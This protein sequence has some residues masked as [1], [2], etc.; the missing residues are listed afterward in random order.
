MSDV[1]FENASGVPAEGVVATQAVT[2]AKKIYRVK[3]CA[4]SGCN[5]EFTPVI[6]AQKF[7]E[8][9]KIRPRTDEDREYD[10]AAQQRHRDK[11]AAKQEKKDRRFDSKT[12][13]TKKEAIEIL[14]KERLIRNPHVVDK[15]VELAES[16]ARHFKI[17]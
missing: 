13:I 5:A 8:L 9:H 10:A 16:A 15:C 4:E 2:P 7:C 1:T 3:R 12:V 17:P 6:G 14:E 11:E